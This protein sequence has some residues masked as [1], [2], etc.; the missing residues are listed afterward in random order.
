[1]SLHSRLKQNPELLNEYD[2]IFKEQQTQGII[3]KVVPENE[4]KDNIYFLSHHGV[5]R[6]DHDTTKLRIVVDGSAKARDESVSFNDRLEIGKNYMPLLF[7]TLLRFRMHSVALT[8]D[9]AKAFLQI[10]IDESDRDY[11]RFLWFDDIRKPGPE[12]I[13]MRYNRLFFGLTCSPAI[14]GETIRHH[15]A[16]YQL[17]SPKHWTRRGASPSGASCTLSRNSH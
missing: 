17:K 13:Q 3:E 8:A 14:L 5:V 7:D 11:L 16:K 15:V 1:M 9:I 4:M 10:E 6:K 2:L 12:I